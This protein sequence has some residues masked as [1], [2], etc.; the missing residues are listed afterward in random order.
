MWGWVVI[1]M[2]RVVG[3]AFAL[4]SWPYV[5]LPIMG[6]KAKKPGNPNALRKSSFIIIYLA[7][8]ASLFKIAVAT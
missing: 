8:E 2:E 4:K 7:K 1:K 6:V 5:K 3:Q